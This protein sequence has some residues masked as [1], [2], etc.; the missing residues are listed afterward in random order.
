MISSSR[1]AGPAFGLQYARVATVALPSA[2][3]KSWS[4]GMLSLAT[5]R[6]VS[7]SAAYTT[8]ELRCLR[9]RLSATA[10]ERLNVTTSKKRARIFFG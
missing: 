4:G 1:N 7:P 6:C 9:R 2:V 3:W 10:R 5:T 8:P